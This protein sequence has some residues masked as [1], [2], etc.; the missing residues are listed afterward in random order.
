MEPWLEASDLH[1]LFPSLVWELQLRRELHEPLD[2]HVLA[3]LA[4]LGQ[5]ELGRG[6]AWQSVQTLHERAEL[7]ELV[8]WIARASDGVLRFLKIGADDLALSACWANVSAPGAGHRMHSH[9]NNFLSGVYYVQV[10]PGADTINFH[11][12]RPQ[13][14][15]IRPP[16]TALT[17]ANTDQ[18]VVRVAAGTLLLFPSWL[19]HSVDPNASGELRV[20]LSFNAMFTDFTE[21]LA[22]PLW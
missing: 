15:I 11:D 14:G 16:V 1:S 17:A 19:P 22:K 21:R 9:P 7:A 20:S 13:T 10:Q 5:P 3:L 18:V 8:E 2:R 12:P 6:E 4:G